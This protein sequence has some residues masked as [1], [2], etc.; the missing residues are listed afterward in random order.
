MAEKPGNAAH[1]TPL[2]NNDHV[3]DNLAEILSART[4]IEASEEA[5]NCASV[6]SDVAHFVKNA[7]TTMELGTRDISAISEILGALEVIAQRIMDWEGKSLG[8]GIRTD[9]EI[10]YI[11]RGLEP[12]DTLSSFRP[13]FPGCH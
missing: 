6:L 7:M 8:L 13:A 4:P 2:W 12:P 11:G 1:Q 10:K 9:L 3:Y 5:F